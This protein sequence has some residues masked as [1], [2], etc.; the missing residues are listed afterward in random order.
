[1]NRFV[2]ASLASLLLFGCAESTRP[3]SDGGTGGDAG[4]ITDGSQVGDGGAD[5]GADGGDAAVVTCPNGSVDLGESCDD[6]NMVNGDG[7]QNDCTF[8][9]LCGN[10]VVETGE[11]CDDGNNKSGD[12]CSGLCLT[13]GCGN[14]RLDP[15]E[16][17]DGTTGCAANCLSVTLCGNST[18]DAGEQCDDGNA[19][20]WD[21]CSSACETEKAVI[22]SDLAIATTT[23]CDWNEDGQGDNALGYALGVAASQL[24]PVISNQLKMPPFI[25]L[26]I[27]GA[28]DPTLVTSDSSIRVAWLAATDA[29]MNAND[30]FGGNGTVHVDPASVS[31][32]Q[33]LIS[34][35]GSVANAIVDAG[36]EDVTLP[37][38]MGTPI[39]LRRARLEHTTF[40]VNTG[41]NPAKYS[42]A[43]N[44]GHLC[45]IVQVS[46]MALLP[47]VLGQLGGAISV[48][49]NSCDPSVANN[50]VTMADVLVGGA[51][52]QNIIPVINA[53]PADVDFDGDGLESFEVTAGTSCQAVITACIDGDGTRIEGHACVT[54]PRMQDGWSSAFDFTAASTRFVP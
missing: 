1:M 16:V 54:D 18:I 38:L 13:E 45:G 44:Q 33:P 41:V 10:H 40:T 28:Q 15:G 2:S 46:T 30:N 24:G 48:P 8:T 14:G 4:E 53:T 22:V 32:G 37:F 6:G 21:G 23:T 5:G 19:T 43:S 29:N 35:P 26:S 12:G 7:C 42:I 36:P 47:N 11:Q 49:T 25:V 39:G 17:C 52:F 50:Q 9:A 51:Y 34:F 20:S 3:G 31:N 27:L